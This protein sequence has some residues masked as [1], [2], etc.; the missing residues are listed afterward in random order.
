MHLH[1]CVCV[2]VCVCVWRERERERER[3]AGMALSIGK[4]H[5]LNCN[6][7]VL[8]RVTF[9]PTLVPC[10]CSI[11]IERERQKTLE[12]SVSAANKFSEA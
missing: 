6:L 2:C 7:S 3:E 4:L 5:M 12:K 8:E 11:M 9:D 1:V 10:A